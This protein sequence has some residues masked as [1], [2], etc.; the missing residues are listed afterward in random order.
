MSVR[1]AVFGLLAL[2]S[3][4]AQAQ[5]ANFEAVADEARKLASQAYAAPS[6]EGVSPE[7]RNL[8]YD[9]YQNI[10]FRPEA[11]L[12]RGRPGLYQ[13][14]LFPAGFLFKEPVRLYVAGSGDAEPI[15]AKPEWFSWDRSGIQSPPSIV[16]VGGFRVHFPLH[17]LNGEEE[18]AAFLG[19]SYFRL[20]GREQVYGA[21]ARGLAID[22]AQPQRK[23]EFPAFRAFWLMPPAPESRELTVLALLDSPSV[24][25][26][27]RFKLLPG[28]TTRLEVTAYLFGR[29]DVSLLGLAPLTSMFLVGENSPKRPADYRPEVHDSD[30]LQLETGSGERLWRPLN[31]PAALSISSFADRNPRGFGLMQ[32]DRDFDHYR[33]TQ[34]RYERRPSLW[35]E[36][37]GEWGEG[38]VRLI[39]IPSP[40][41]K[42]DN[43]VA[44]WVR[45]APLK[46]GEHLEIAY[47]L[48]ALADEQN[49]APRG[50]AMSSTVVPANLPGSEGHSPTMRRGFVEFTGGDLPVL[51]S[52]Q[53][54]AGVVE[55]SA[56]KLLRAQAEK[57]P[58][59]H[60][61][62][63][64][65][66]F[67]PE[68]KAPI[69]VR[70][71]LK[72]YDEPL[73]ETWLY[74]WRP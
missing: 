72:L 63:L 41:E 57:I 65:F 20:I 7:F 27:Y 66:E 43:V 17:K 54:V 47:R 70:A 69:D 71:A 73:T 1:A 32:R 13:L 23:E 11:A 10:R 3:V 45:K 30:G 14:Q 21:S 56:G 4:G 44:F 24:A 58:E 29:N 6:G 33:D 55:L 61:W 15:S 22:T 19:A 42:H 31:N 60:S 8:N 53:P 52:E 35:V 68:G 36:P 28:T 67:E 38:E 48:Y 25:G 46:K 5:S 2:V 49:L 18:V 50:R 37:I 26:A 34:A 9:A 12:W 39:E 16:P 64:M 74:Q 62:R 40:A 51:R 59:R